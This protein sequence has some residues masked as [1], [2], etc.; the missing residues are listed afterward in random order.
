MNAKFD[1]Y[2]QQFWLWEK[3]MP[4]KSWFFFWSHAILLFWCVAQSGQQFL[5][6]IICPGRTSRSNLIG[7]LN[8]YWENTKNQFRMTAGRIENNALSV[9]FF[10]SCVVL[11]LK[12][13]NTKKKQ[14]NGLPHLYSQHE[15]VHCP[16]AYANVLHRLG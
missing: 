16:K 4:R 14:T 13:R 7:H 12:N 1:F 9:C 11:I 15:H 2:S 6:R 3:N 8:G 10:V 5:K